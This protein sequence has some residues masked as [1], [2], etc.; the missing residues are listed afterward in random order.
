[1]ISNSLDH[2]GIR[3]L[4][5]A[6]TYLAGL[7][8]VDE[9]RL[10]TIGFSLGGS[11]AVAW[12]CVDDRLKAAASYYG[13][14][15]RPLEAVGNA[16]PVVGSYPE[17]DF[18]RA[19]GALLEKELR[20]HGLPNDIKVY[21]GTRHSFFNEHREKSLRPGSLGRLLAP[22]AEVLPGARLRPR[23][24]KHCECSKRAKRRR[25]IVFGDLLPLVLY[26]GRSPSTASKPDGPPE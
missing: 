10:G 6:L 22:H 24:A 16:C 23:R 14:N 17:K 15:P 25:E 20:R 12:S 4:K 13:V 8:V 2:G 26:L 3:D 5:S 21:P 9:D 11:L 7:E 19:Q 18:T 1:M